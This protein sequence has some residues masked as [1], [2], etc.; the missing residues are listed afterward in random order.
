VELRQNDIKS[1]TVMMTIIDLKENQSK[2]MKK[3]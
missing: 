1:P 2:R 3:E